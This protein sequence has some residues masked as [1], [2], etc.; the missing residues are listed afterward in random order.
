MFEYGK[1]P[2]PVLDLIKLFILNLRLRRLISSTRNKVSIPLKMYK[3]HIN[4][5][6]IVMFYKDRSLRALIILWYSIIEITKSGFEN[7]I[8]TTTNLWLVDDKSYINW[9]LLVR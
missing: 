1:T 7:M 9:T 6:V 5:P 8:E 3:L 4:Y 2:G